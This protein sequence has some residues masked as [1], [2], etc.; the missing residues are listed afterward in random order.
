MGLQILILGDIIKLVNF[1]KGDCMNEKILNITNGDVFNEYL[2]SKCDGI[3]V[4]FCEA[5]MDGTTIKDIYS[6]DFVNLRSAELNVDI[7]VYKSKMYVYDALKEERYS[8]LILWF[9]KDTFCQMNLLTLLAYLE[10]IKFCGKIT[11][12]YIDDES[13]EIIEPNINVTLGSYVKI[14]E[15]ILIYKHIHNEVGVLS[16]RE[17]E[18]YFDYHS[19]NGALARMIRDNCDKKSI[20]LVCLLLENSKEY[21]LSD[22]QA[23]K[24]IKKY[25]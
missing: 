6:K 14:Y 25:V 17:I 8:K 18:L 9:G 2:L 19:D 15:E 13:F 11:L 10:Q 24:L 21:G 5:M 1:F 22:I 3:A 4:P 7:E 12:N 16:K 20:E 23:K